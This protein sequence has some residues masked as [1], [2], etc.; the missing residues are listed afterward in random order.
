[1]SLRVVLHEDRALQ[2]HVGDGLGDLGLAAA[3]DGGGLV[4]ERAIRA[5]ADQPPGRAGEL[6]FQP[7]PVP[8]RQHVDVSGA[9]RDLPCAGPAIPNGRSL[10]GH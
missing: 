6:L 1:M 9:Q 2:Q 8:R 3:G 5:R 10:R 7:D 4:A